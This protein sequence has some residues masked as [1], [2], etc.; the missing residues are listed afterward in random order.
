MKQI[1]KAFNLVWQCSR[2]ALTLKILY[3][4]IQSVLPLCNLYLLKLLV[5][6][7]T[8]L[9]GNE[10][11]GQEVAGAWLMMP[12]AIVTIAFCSL[13]LLNRLITTLSNLNND[14]LQQRLV[15]YVSNIIHTQS[16][17]LDMAYYD[18]PD[19]HDTFH[20]AQQEATY[21][22]MQV[23][24]NLLGTAGAILSIAGV[25]VLVVSWSWEVLLLMI[26]SILPSFFVKLAKSKRI[27]AFRRATT[28]LSRRSNY[29]SALLTGYLSA[30]EVRA[31]GL[32][33]MLTKRFVGVRAMLVSKILKISRWIAAC[34][35]L[36][37]LLETMALLAVIVILTTETVAGTMTIGSFVMIFEAFRRGQ[38]YMNALVTGISGIY[39]NRLFLNN[40]LEFLELKP[41]IVSPDVAQK[42]PEVV[43]RVDFEHITFAYPPN[44]ENGRRVDVL[45]DFSLTAKRGAITHITGE[46]G[47]GKTTL[48]KLMLRLYDPDEGRITINGIDIKEFDLN[49]LRRGVSAVFQDYM[50]YY[51]TAGENVRMGDVEQMEQGDEADDSLRMTEALRQSGAE[52]IMQRLPE[53][54]GT[55]LGRM[56]DKGEELSMGQWQ[57][58]ALARQLYRQAQVLVFDEPMAWMDVESRKEFRAHL[59]EL[60]ENHVVI[61]ISHLED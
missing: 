55:M 43:E 27:Y 31:F 17:K 58:I 56:F 22:P 7:V 51:F 39:D 49:D 60:K 21:R 29:F 45:K 37:A 8:Q 6:E 12:L 10:S 13:F 33:P 9:I 14:I 4:V 61:L 59:E 46:N 25:T 50:R 41:K 30:K 3:T 1:A 11:V 34:D 16:A 47:Y 5:D 54:L 36:C 18:N 42:F 48:L 2:K 57:R 28:Q 35:A 40:L 26:V 53:G 15:D 19:Y 44:T 38:G 32:T 24:N 20:R 52:K 23:I